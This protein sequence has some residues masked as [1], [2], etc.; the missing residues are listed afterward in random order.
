MVERLEKKCIV[1]NGEQRRLAL[2]SVE[3][4]E[5]MWVVRN[6]SISAVEVGGGARY[7]RLIECFG[8]D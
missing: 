4:I 5:I 2:L 6:G 3:I 8:L 7:W 1:R